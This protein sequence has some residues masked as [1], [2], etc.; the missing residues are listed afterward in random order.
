MAQTAL[1]K[2]KD[3]AAELGFEGGGKIQDFLEFLFPP[4]EVPMAAG[5]TIGPKAIPLFQSSKFGRKALKEVLDDIDNVTA[6]GP[7]TLEGLINM[8]NIKKNPVFRARTASQDSLP[9]RLF[10]NQEL[11]DDAPDVLIDDLISLVSRLFT[12]PRE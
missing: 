12:S 2:P 11:I 5:T 10:A 9:H 3:V 1:R 6:E 4:D 7:N 8:T